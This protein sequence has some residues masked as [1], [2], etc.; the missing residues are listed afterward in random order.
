[1]M[2]SKVVVL[3]VACLLCVGDAL[4]NCYVKKEGPVKEVVLSPLPHTYLAPAD[5]PSAWDWRNVS[6]LNLVTASR[7]QHIPQYCGSCWAHGT[8]SALND[9]ISIVRKGAWPEVMLAPQMLINCEGG[10]DCD[11]G[12]AGAAYDF[13]HS[14]GI[15]EESCAPYQAVNGLACSPACKSCTG[16]NETCTEVKTATLWKVGEFGH[17]AGETKM[18]AEIYARGPIACSIHA[19]DKLEAYTGGIFKEFV[20]APVP[21]H[22]VSVVGWGEENGQGY[23]I[24]RNSWGNYWGESGWFRIVTGLFTDN[25]G[26]QQD[27]YWAVP[28]IPP[29]Y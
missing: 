13:I 21:N 3:L 18:K 2:G 19:D 6:G 9:R 23:W 4:K 17:V 27:C 12:D 16:F 29:G 22:I 15:V 11:G 7:N 24:V 25:L 5:V 8:T 14:E 20:P 1:M 26:I 10:G 28:E